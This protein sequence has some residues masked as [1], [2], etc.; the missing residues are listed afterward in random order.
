[1]IRKSWSGYAPVEATLELLASALRDVKDR[2]RQLF[3]QERT[4]ANAGLFLDGLLSEEQRKTGWMRS[5]A[6]GDPGPWR[7]QDCLAG[8]VGMPMRCGILFASMSSNICA[9]MTQCW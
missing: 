7:Q 2:M 4:A 3:A 9:M 1:M 6:A 8:T 5:E